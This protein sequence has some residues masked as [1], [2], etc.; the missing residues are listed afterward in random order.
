ML[1]F[2][3]AVERDSVIDAWLEHQPGELSAIA[4]WWYAQFRDCS[5]DVRELM[6]DASPAACIEDVA[7]GDVSVFKAR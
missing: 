3:G 1:R 2:D 4:R 6:H 7:F 5:D